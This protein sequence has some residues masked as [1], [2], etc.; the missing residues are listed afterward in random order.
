V[1]DPNS[2]L[3]GAS[4]QTG[5]AGGVGF[6]SAAHPGSNAPAMLNMTI[7]MSRVVR[8]IQPVSLIKPGSTSERNW[9]RA[10]RS[11]ASRL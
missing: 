11:A 4:S 9:A 2:R 7:G 8:T 1:T 3:E 6:T 5:S 10:W